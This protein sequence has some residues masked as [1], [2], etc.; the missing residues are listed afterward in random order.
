MEIQLKPADVFLTQGNSLLSK[1]IRFFSRSIGESRTKVNHVGIVV[2]EESLQDALVIEALSKVKKH[3]LWE[4]YG[5]L[6]EDLVAVYRPL[7]L[8][9][10]EIKTIVREAEEQVGKKYG[11]LKIIAH[12]LDWIFLGVYFFRRFTNNGNYPIC[13][14]LV[15]HAYSKA[16]KYFGCDPGAA[17][18][19][20]IWDFVNRNTDKYKEI[21]PLESIW[22]DKLNKKQVA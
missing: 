6:K 15:A 20:D 3:T 13:S 14:W 7:N 10:A 2:S 5:P 9:L 1:A 18:P 4:Q 8:T 19:D 16:G 11:Y 22:K 12:L 17:E 21:Y